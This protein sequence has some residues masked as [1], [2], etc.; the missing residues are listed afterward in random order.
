[1]RE[2]TCTTAYQNTKTQICIG[3]HIP[4]RDVRISDESSSIEFCTHQFSSKSV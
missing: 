1:M 2:M 3:D 4:I